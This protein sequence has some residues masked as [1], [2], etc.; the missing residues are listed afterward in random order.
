MVSGVA[1]GRAV[2]GSSAVAYLR[3]IKD[4]RNFVLLPFGGFVGEGNISVFSAGIPSD[5][6]LTALNIELD[7]E[8]TF[9]LI[10]NNQMCDRLTPVPAPLIPSSW[11]RSN[12]TSFI[13]P[14]GN[15]NF[16]LRFTGSINGS[17]VAGGFIKISYLTS[18]FSET[19]ASSLAYQFPTINGLINLYDGFFIGGNVTS[20][21]ATLRFISNYTTYLTIGNASF[22]FAGSNVTQSVNIT[23][24]MMQGAFTTAGL[25]YADVSRK[26][27]PI[28]FGVGEVTITGAPADIV[29]VSD[30]SGSMGW[31]ISNDNSPPCPSGDQLKITSAVNV[32]NNFVSSILN[33]TIAGSRVGLAEFGGAIKSWHNL[34]AN[35]SPL[36]TQIGT[37]SAS[38]ST[39]ICCGINNATE[40]LNG[41]GQIVLI[42]R[43]T[44]GW[45]YND[46]NVA[47][48]AG[49]NLTTF[50]ASLW[51]SGTTPIGW[52]YGSLNT[53]IAAGNRYTGVYLHRRNFTV[54][55]TSQLYDARLYVY[56]DDGADVY[57]N[58]VRVDADYGNVHNALYWN[59]NAIFVN[60]SILVN[61]TNVIAVRQYHGGGAGNRM[62]FDLQLIANTQ[63]NVTATQTKSI[64]IMTDGAATVTCAQQGT[65]NPTQDAIKA[66]CDAYNNYG[67]VVHTVGFGLGADNATM[68]QMAN[69]TTGTYFLANNASALSQAFES[70]AGTII[71]NSNTQTAILA[72]NISH[73]ILYGDSVVHANYTPDITPPQPNEISV[74]LQSN[75]LGSCNANVTIYP[76]MRVLDAALTSYSG[77]YWTNGLTANGASVYNLSKYSSLYASL[78]DPY[79]VNIPVNTLVPGNN[80]L[81]LSLGTDAFNSSFNCSANNTFIYTVAINL[82]T[83]RSDVVERAE[84]CRW[85]VQFANSATL[86]LTIPS[87]YTGSNVCSYRSGNL[88]YDSAD[89]YQLGAFTIFDRLD[90]AR[91]GTVFVDLRAEDLEVIVTTISRVPYLWG[92]ALLRLEVA[93]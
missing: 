65:G 93:R 42:A 90:F 23:E 26:T 21:N 29:V 48:P 73:M 8:R 1:E 34:T 71:E 45:K 52:T 40:S 7:T 85:T 28:R 6:N 91:D 24:A 66:A 43:S 61:G 18:Q 16:T 11:N 51:K 15:N 49:W 74:A 19:N 77:E 86:N 72:G 89:A 55:D 70:I 57:I 22:S 38:G 88:T 80:T 30:T 17:S 59:R 39:C 79:R 47:P 82:S 53:V 14:G 62:G 54:N 81:T 75:P 3:R 35:V 9:D 27:V 92:P 68:Q 69:C 32:T 87:S 10:I 83:E 64:V 44:S 60:K 58:G 50:N 25:S 31:C 67:I 84:G 41:E 20:L 37:Y 33:G 36:L 5:A 46:S 76:G 78:G 13:T 12:C 2:T 63:G 4:K 56:S